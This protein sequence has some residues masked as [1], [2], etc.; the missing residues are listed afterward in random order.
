MSAD[1]IG[2]LYRSSDIY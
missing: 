1:K 2:R